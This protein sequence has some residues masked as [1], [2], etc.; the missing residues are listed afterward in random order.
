[1]VLYAHVKLRWILNEQQCL[2]THVSLTLTKLDLLK[3][4]KVVQS[5]LIFGISSTLSLEILWSEGYGNL[6]FTL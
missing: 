4:F 2:I 3:S 6:L 5:Y 1:M